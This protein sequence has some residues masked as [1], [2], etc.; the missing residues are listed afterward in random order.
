MGYNVS[1]KSNWNFRTVLA[2]FACV[3]AVG[4]KSSKKVDD[5]AA[6]AGDQAPAIDSAAMNFDAM[7]SD[8][9]KIEGL[10][11]IGFEYDRSVLGAEAKKILKGNAEWMKKNS[12]TK[13]TIEGHC[14]ARGSQEYNLALGE[15][16]AKAVR[17]YMQSLG[18]AADRMSVVSYGK[19]RLLANGDSEADHSRN[20]RANFVPV[21]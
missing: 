14:D 7:G 6:A 2:A 4:C 16:R 15:R 18:V 13:L 20:R 8:S 10:R 1:T 5:S 11:S 9:G 19:E 21:Q 12:G 17:A 3:V